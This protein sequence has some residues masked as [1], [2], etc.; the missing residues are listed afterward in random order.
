MGTNGV[1]V[2]SAGDL[3]SGLEAYTDGFKGG[4]ATWEGLFSWR[5][6]ANNV[7]GPVRLQSIWNISYHTGRLLEP[8]IMGK[9]TLSRNQYLYSAGFLTEKALEALILRRVTLAIPK[10]NYFGI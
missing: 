10:I 2:Q 6:I 4:L 7:N 5:T 8:Y 9:K 1:K 3:R